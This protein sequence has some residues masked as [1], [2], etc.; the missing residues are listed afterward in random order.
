[1]ISTPAAIALDDLDETVTALRFVL[2][3]EQ[4]PCLPQ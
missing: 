4:V 3:L 2:Q 1:M